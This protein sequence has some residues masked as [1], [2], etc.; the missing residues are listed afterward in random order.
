M[1]VMLNKSPTETTVPMFAILTD[2]TETTVPMFATLT[3]MSGI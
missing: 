1:S 2:P 3:E